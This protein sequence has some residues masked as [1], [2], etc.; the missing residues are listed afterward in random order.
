[1]ESRSNCSSATRFADF[2]TSGH[3]RHVAKT[4]VWTGD[5]GT[6]I[7]SGTQRSS[8]FRRCRPTRRHFIHDSAMAAGE[9]STRFRGEKGARYFD[10]QDRDIEAAAR[11]DRWKFDA[12]VHDEDTV[13]DFGCATGALLATLPGQRKI[14]VE[15]NEPALARARSRGFDVV[16][17]S[18][19]LPSNIADVVIS[20]HALEHTLHPMLELRELWRALKPGGRLVLWLPLDDWRV[21]RSPR[22]DDSDQHLY[23]WTPLLLGNLLAEARFRVE[24]ARVVASAWRPNYV[25]AQER[26]PK[27][28]YGALTFFTAWA[29]RRRQLHALATKRD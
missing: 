10:P 26:L 25:P 21:Q 20:N 14:G 22:D 2:A 11:L 27:P 3:R 6:A 23:T 16:S 4:S 17:S 19:E 18:A 12:Y 24:T 5:V 15:V 7:A 13:V 9:P 28:V 29:L 1:M 8:R